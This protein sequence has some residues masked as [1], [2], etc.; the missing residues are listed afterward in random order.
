MRSPVRLLAT[1]SI[2]RNEA[3]IRGIAKSRLADQPSAGTYRNYREDLKDTVRVS[4]DSETT[5][6]YLSSFK[7]FRRF[8]SRARIEHGMGSILIRLDVENQ[9]QSIEG[10]VDELGDLDLVRIARHMRAVKVNLE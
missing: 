3:S 8:E 7:P 2:K 6:T 4:Y 9:P 10:R 5:D 1:R